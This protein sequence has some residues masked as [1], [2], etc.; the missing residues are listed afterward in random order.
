[1][2]R[3]SACWFPTNERSFATA[4]TD[5]AA[6]VASA[7]GVPLLGILL[8]TVGWRWSF[9]ATGA[10]SLLYLLVFRW[11]IA[12]PKKIPKLTDAERR[13]IAATAGERAAGSC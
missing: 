2:R 11:C 5:A 12:I 10:I 6:K 3:R 4:L 7:I 13:L 9:A 8:L 1:M